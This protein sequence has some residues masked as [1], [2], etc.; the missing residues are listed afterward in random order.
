MHSSMPRHLLPTLA[1]SSRFAELEGPISLG[2]SLSYLIFGGMQ[3]SDP[4]LAPLAQPLNHRFAV[5][6]RG[7]F[8]SGLVEAIEQVLNMGGLSPVKIVHVSDDSVFVVLDVR[9]SSST[10]PKIDAIWSAAISQSQEPARTVYFASENDIW[11]DHSDYAYPEA[12][13]EILNEHVLGVC[14]VPSTARELEDNGGLAYDEAQTALTP[15]AVSPI[16]S[17]LASLQDELRGFFGH[18][19]LRMTEY[20]LKGRGESNHQQRKNLVSLLALPSGLRQSQ[21]TSIASIFPGRGRDGSCLPPPEQIRTCGTTAYGSCLGY[22]T[23]SD[24]Q[25]MGVHFW[26]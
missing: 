21:I 14:P 11:S 26:V 22:V 1:T 10:V 2:D 6:F 23:R 17:A 13:R 3:E 8:E 7:D 19:S 24:L 15:G 20:Y 9:T 5:I 12:A 16:P 4:N 18:A 25:G